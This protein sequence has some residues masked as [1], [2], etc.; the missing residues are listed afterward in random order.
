MSR[1]PRPCFAVGSRRRQATFASRTAAS[2]PSFVLV[3]V[4]VLALPSSSAA[5]ATSLALFPAAG[6]ASAEQRAALDA[7]LRKALEAE[8]DVALLSAA[9]TADNVKFM[10]EGGALCTPSDLA[11]LQKFGL[12]ATVDRLLV[13]EARGRRTLDVTLTVVDVASGEVVRTADGAVSPR[14]APAIASLVRR[15]LHGDDDEKPAGPSKLD[16]PPAAPPRLLDG[17]V[18]DET[19]L[20]GLQAAAAWTAG[21]GGGVGALG[22]LGALGGEAVFWTGSGTKEVRGGIVKPFAQAMWFVTMV[23][24]AAAGVGGAIYLSEVPP[25]PARL[26]P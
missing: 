26:D 1:P 7:A 13:A 15:A 16:D 24:A 2:L 8:D 20:R 19:E 9:E 14:D 4:L 21:I 6:T 12:V 17:P 18:V 11:C 25:D 10:A 23:G 3:L 22:L 5:A